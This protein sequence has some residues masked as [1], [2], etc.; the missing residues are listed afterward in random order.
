MSTRLGGLTK[1]LAIGRLQIAA[2][3]RANGVA[4]WLNEL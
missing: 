4:A 2:G 3:L 1:D